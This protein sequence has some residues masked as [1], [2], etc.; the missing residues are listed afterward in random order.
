MGPPRN[1][2]T[3]HHRLHRVMFETY[4]ENHLACWRSIVTHV[5]RRHESLRCQSDTVGTWL[6][7][8]YRVAESLAAAYIALTGTLDCMYLMR[9][10]RRRMDSTIPHQSRHRQDNLL[11]ELNINSGSSFIRTSKSCFL[12]FWGGGVSWPSLIKSD[13]AYDVFVPPLYT[14]QL[15][16][17]RLGY[18][19]SY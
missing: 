3:H 15:T 16:W 12:F 10:R 14:Q 7:I 2:F 6:L 19:A 18:V 1:K 4:Y 5:F 17:S 13:S 8:F 9:Y 11:W